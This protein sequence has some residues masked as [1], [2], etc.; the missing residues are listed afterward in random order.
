MQALSE[1]I[2][3]NAHSLSE[4]IRKSNDKLGLILRDTKS[5]LKALNVESA[6]GKEEREAPVVL[7]VDSLH[8]ATTA[9]WAND[10]GAGPQVTQG[11]VS[12]P[13]LG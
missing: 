8:R 4:E 1:S 13:V 10:T 12:R 3:K 2:Q 11:P 9:L 6:E 5:V 7:P